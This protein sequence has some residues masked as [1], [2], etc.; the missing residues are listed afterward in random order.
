MTN[1]RSLFRGVAFGEE[2]LQRAMRAEDAPC[3]LPCIAGN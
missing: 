2:S 3:M 1:E